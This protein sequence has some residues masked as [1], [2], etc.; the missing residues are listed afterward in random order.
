MVGTL[1]SICI[2]QQLNQNDMVRPDE[3]DVWPPLYHGI[4][5]FCFALWGDRTGMAGV[6]ARC[7]TQD[8]TLG[9]RTA[10]NAG[11]AA[12]PK[13]LKAEKNL[14]SKLETCPY[15]HKAS[16]ELKSCNQARGSSRCKRGIE[17]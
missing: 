5:F 16:A 7:P 2:A 9:S 11:T 6:L 17:T 10:T 12:T 3:T 8:I 13:G 14:E 1:L 4:L 15:F